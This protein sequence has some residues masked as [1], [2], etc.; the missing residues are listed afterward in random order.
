MQWWSWQPRGRALTHYP[1][2]QRKLRTQISIPFVKCISCIHDN[3]VRELAYNENTFGNISNPLPAKVFHPV[4][5][6]SL[7]DYCRKRITLFTTGKESH[8][9]ITYAMR[10]YMFLRIAPNCIFFFLFLLVN[11]NNNTEQSLQLKP[12]SNEINHNKKAIWFINIICLFPN[13]YL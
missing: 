3:D 13:A 2:H 7:Q 10:D 9:G 12:L 1:E 4:I 5:I 8:F 11:D 6:N